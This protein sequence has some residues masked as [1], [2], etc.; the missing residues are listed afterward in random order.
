MPSCA[1]SG[2]SK[3]TIPDDGGEGAALLVDARAEAGNPRQREG[4]VIIPARKG[5]ALS[6]VGKLVNT[7]DEGRGILRRKA[8]LV[9]PEQSAAAFHRKRKPGDHKEVGSALL[10][11][12]AQKFKRIHQESSLQIRQRG[13]CA[14]PE[15]HGFFD[16]EA[17]GLYGAP[18]FDPAGKSAFRDGVRNH[19]LDRA[20]FIHRNLIAQQARTIVTEAVVQNRGPLQNFG[21]AGAGS[22]AGE[23]A[24]SKA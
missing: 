15:R 7:V 6:A 11:C 19:R 16:G 13:G 2:S 1:G 23:E 14:L 5:G 8:V 21:D 22:S 24:F 17:P 20:V 18:A 12:G 10:D 9:P 4:K 3:R